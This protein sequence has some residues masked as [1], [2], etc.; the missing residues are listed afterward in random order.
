MKI[1]VSKVIVHRAEGPSHECVTKEFTGTD[2]LGDAQHQMMLWSYSAP[3]DGGYDK[4]DF[5]IHFADGYVYQGRYDLTATGRD[6]SDD[7]I[8][9]HVF[10]FMQFIAGKRRPLHLNEKQYAQVMKRY[11]HLK[12]DAVKFLETYDLGLAA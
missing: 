7:S 9:T 2:A 6:S 8:R 12:D 11:E 4:C 3:K 10:L 5:W 1:Q